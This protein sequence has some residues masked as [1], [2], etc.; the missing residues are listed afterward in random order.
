[1]FACE[2]GPIEPDLMCLSKGLTGG[3]LPLAATL[4]SEEIFEAFLSEDR[5]ETFFHGH[6]FTANALSC[7]VALE[8]LALFDESE[9]RSSKRFSVQP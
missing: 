7:A 9:D 2:H 6:S 1:M 8:S 5:S 4:A 3:Y